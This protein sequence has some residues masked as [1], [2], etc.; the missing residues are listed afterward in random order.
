MNKEKIFEHYKNY[1]NNN[2]KFNTEKGESMSEI[3]MFSEN[4]KIGSS[5]ITEKIVGKVD[6]PFFIENVIL[7][8]PEDIELDKKSLKNVKG[9][10]KSFNLYISLTTM[11]KISLDSVK[12]ELKNKVFDKVKDIIEE[13]E[14]IQVF[15][16]EENR[17]NGR[18]IY[19]I[20]PTE[21][22]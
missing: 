10:I 15:T 9:M 6:V 17:F 21:V 5:E 8:F 16:E 14:I 2:I 11:K 3:W 7:D 1:I 19:K 20:K 4:R 22:I 12:D 18:I 13:G